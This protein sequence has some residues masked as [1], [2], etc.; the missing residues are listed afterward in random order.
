MRAQALRVGPR[1]SFLPPDKHRR[2]TKPRQSIKLGGGGGYH[3]LPARQSIS[4][5]T[6]V[7]GKVMATSCCYRV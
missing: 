6:E 5:A 7:G 1:F 4:R 2:L 3:T